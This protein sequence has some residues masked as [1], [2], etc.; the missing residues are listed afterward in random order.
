M[1]TF[2]IGAL[3]FTTGALMCL[4]FVSA[5]LCDAMEHGEVYVRWINF[6]KKEEG[7]C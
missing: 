7:T 4:V 2:T 5:L 6:Q 3:S 1:K